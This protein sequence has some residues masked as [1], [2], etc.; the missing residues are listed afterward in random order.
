M[1]NPLMNPLMA[2]Q[3]GMGMGMNFPTPP[4]SAPGVMFP[5]MTGNPMDMSTAG[6]NPYMMP[7][8]STPWF[9]SG[10]AAAFHV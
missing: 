7:M 4:V 9:P 8:M 3:P 1:L 2:T 10:S 5:G 6:Y